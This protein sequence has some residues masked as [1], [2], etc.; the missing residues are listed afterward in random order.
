MQSIKKHFSVILGNDLTG[1]LLHIKL[2]HMK[3]AIATEKLHTLCTDSTNCQCPIITEDKACS[4][5]T[6]INEFVHE[7]NPVAITFDK[8]EDYDKFLAYITLASLRG[9]KITWVSQMQPLTLLLQD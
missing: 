5:V 4:I 6:L 2:V 3:S 1:L 8:A 9:W 7:T